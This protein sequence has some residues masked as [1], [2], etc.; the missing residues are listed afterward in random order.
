MSDAKVLW[1]RTELH[2][3]GHGFG[4]KL[5]T[6]ARLGLV[7]RS[8][9]SASK[10]PAQRTQGR[11]HRTPEGA[12]CIAGWAWR[13]RHAPPCRPVMRNPASGTQSVLAGQRGRLR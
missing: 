10:V 7:E 6:T 8:W 3:G 4:C 5:G 1:N 11:A 9:H 13:C 12:R 2:L